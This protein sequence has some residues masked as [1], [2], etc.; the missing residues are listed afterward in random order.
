M[1]L[2]VSK[3]YISTY[4]NI[5]GKNNAIDDSTKQWIKKICGQQQNK[6]KSIVNLQFNCQFDTNITAKSVNSGL[7]AGNLI[8]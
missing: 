1:K 7:L 6:Y 5:Q 2:C 8:D 3:L 4:N